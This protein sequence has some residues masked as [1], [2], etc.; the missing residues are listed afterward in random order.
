MSKEIEKKLIPFLENAKPGKGMDSKKLKD[1]VEH[2]KDI[3]KVLDDFSVDKIDPITA[4]RKI[5]EISGG[6][7]L[8]EILDQMRNITEAAFKF[9]G[10]GK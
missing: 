5:R 1:T 3:K 10:V 8:P 9:G 6:K 7:D 4:S 2:F